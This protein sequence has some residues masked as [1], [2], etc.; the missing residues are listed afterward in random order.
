MR[1]DGLAA[2]GSGAGLLLALLAT[3]GVDDDLLTR[4]GGTLEAALTLG[5][6]PDTTGLTGVLTADV[7]GVVTVTATAT[8]PLPPELAISVELRSL[9]PGLLDLTGTIAAP[10]EALL[11]V[12]GRLRAPTGGVMLA[13]PLRL[14]ATTEWTHQT[15]VADGGA[16]VHLEA[17]SVPRATPWTLEVRTSVEDE[18]PL[19]V[20]PVTDPVPPAPPGRERPTLRVLSP[21]G[22]GTAN[23]VLTLPRAGRVELEVFEIGGR[24]L[25]RGGHELGVGAHRLEVEGPEHRLPPGVHLVRVTVDDAEGRVRLMQKLV[26]LRPPQGG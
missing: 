18:T 2:P 6:P 9:E 7:A 24:L 26:R 13:A 19:A 10:G 3:P 20:D 4:A 16:R 22:A 5:S 17:S 21:P 25:H 14:A 1:V 11:P 12:A 8:D 23:V 15:P